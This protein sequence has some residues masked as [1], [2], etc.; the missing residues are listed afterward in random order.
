MATRFAGDFFGVPLVSARE[1]KDSSLLL[2]YFPDLRKT[3]SAEASE[4]DK[5]DSGARSFRGRKA[6]A[7]FTGFKTMETST[8]NPKAAPVFTGFK[9]FE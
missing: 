9:T 4:R 5:Q 2:D 8:K 3:T 7:P 6:V 1:E